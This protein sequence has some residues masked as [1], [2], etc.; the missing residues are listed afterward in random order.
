MFLFSSEL[1][2]AWI[3]LA[4]MRRVLHTAKICNL[5]FVFATKGSLIYIF[6]AFNTKEN[7][8]SDNEDDEEY[9]DNCTITYCGAVLKS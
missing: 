3:F 6:P 7:E 9:S 4:Q 2:M 1:G 5:Q 8:D